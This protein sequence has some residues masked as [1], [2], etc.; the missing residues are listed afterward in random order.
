ML[1]YNTK[2]TF[3]INRLKLI[4]RLRGHVEQYKSD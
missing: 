1:F 3:R 2:Y 4:N